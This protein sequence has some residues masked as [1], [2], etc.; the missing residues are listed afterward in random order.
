M[1]MLCEK[2]E[3][4][5]MDKF[6]DIDNAN[7]QYSDFQFQQLHFLSCSFYAFLLENLVCCFCVFE[8][9]SPHD[10]SWAH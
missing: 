4:F 7:K 5:I 9:L 6:S 2:P 8:E 3:K 10:S 1:K